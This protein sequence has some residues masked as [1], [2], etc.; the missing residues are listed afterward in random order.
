[1]VTNQKILQAFHK[2]TERFHVLACWIGIGLNLLWSLGDYFTIKDLWLPFFLF[3]LTVCL[4]CL[5][6][7]ILR[8]LKFQLSIYTCMFVFILG[9]SIQN[10]YMWSMMDVIHFQKHT[11]AYMAL[12]ICAGM[13]VLWELIYSIVLLI[14]TVVSII[15]FYKLNSNLS[16]DEYVSNGGLLL[17]TVLVA[18][19][20][21]IRQRYKLTYNE[22]KSR[23]ELEES[24]DI[25]FIQKQEVEDKNI[26]ITSSLRY[27]SRLQEALLP[28]KNLMDS[29]FNDNYFIFYQPK[30]IVCGDFYWARKINTTPASGEAKEFNL[31]AVGDCT[32]HGVPGAF[33]SLLG[34]NFLHQ[35]A[36][37]KTVNSPA[38]ALDFLNNKIINA[39]NNGYGEEIRDGMDIAFVAIDFNSY[40]ISFAGANNSI[41]IAHKGEI[42]LLKADKQAIGNINDTI[43]PFTNH[44]KQL[45][46]NDCIYLFTDGFADQ[47][48]GVDG[49]KFM[50]KQFE[51]LLKRCCLLSINEQ[52]N[53]IKNTFLNWKGSLEQTDDVCVVGIKF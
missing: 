42:E 3:R 5:V 49:K 30:D 18:S 32:G 22:I 50:R 8:Q 46:K 36:T 6:C 24:K 35:S 16:V 31:I 27:A 25:I 47:F 41:Y 43:K 34:S 11:F 51:S 2:S 44:T 20:F 52:Q 26:E 1:M 13:L 21:I 53:E 7:L 48:G 12:F 14:G 40:T 45:Q 23:L 39:L 4:I 37:E 15:L 17:I 19:V 10:A 28:S 33:M 9:I 38:Q 29:Y